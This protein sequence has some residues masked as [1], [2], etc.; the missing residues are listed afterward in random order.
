MLNCQFCGKTF[1]SNKSLKRHEPKCEYI[2]LTCKF[3]GKICKNYASYIQHTSRCTSNPDRYVQSFS[4]NTRKILAE[5]ARNIV[6]T[7]EMRKKHS[8]A[9]KK[10]VENNPDS[11]ST[12]NVSG[13]VKNI[14]YNGNTFKGTWELQV[15]K[16]L[17]DA[18][19]KYTN[20]V[21]GIPYF[22]NET[23][24]WHTYFPDFYLPEYDLYVEVKGYQRERDLDKWS[25]VENLIVLK[26]SEINAL[27]K[28]KSIIEYIT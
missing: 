22:W 3:C 18:N 24:S 23:N 10:A 19:I 12:S 26:G 17:D 16:S 14:E 6:W 11:Y 5:Q 20:S 13:R 21:Y 27:Q 8:I 7:D 9:M 25:S 28:G 4:E 2:D 15:A 1:N